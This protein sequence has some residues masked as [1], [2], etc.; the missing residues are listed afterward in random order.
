MARIPTGAAR[1]DPYQGSKFR[2]KWDGNYV[3]GASK[4]SAPKWT[5]ELV[6]TRSGGDVSSAYKMPG[7]IKFEA[8]TIERGITHDME[9]ERWANKVW[10]IKNSFGAETSMSDF[11]KD[12]TLELYNEAGQ[13][14]MSWNFFNCWVSEYG[15]GEFDANTS[16]VLIEMIKIENEGFVRDYDVPAPE[17]LSFTSPV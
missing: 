14:A 3:L 1:L 8:I 10:N 12:F 15:L 13:L 6:E 5:S 9:F 7:Q 17:E 2:L 4:V 11:R 16:G